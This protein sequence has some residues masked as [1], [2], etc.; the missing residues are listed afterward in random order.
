MDNIKGQVVSSMTDPLEAN[1]TYL[2]PPNT[3]YK[4][5]PMDLSVNKLAKDFFKRKFK[6]WYATKLAEQLSDKSDES[7]ELQPVSLG[8]PILKELGAMWMV[9]MSEQGRWHRGKGQ[10]PPQKY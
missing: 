7:T 5:Q 6:D 4:L 8:L 9:E 1:H 2:L 10:M 3:T